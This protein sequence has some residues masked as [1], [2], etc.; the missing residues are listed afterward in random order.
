MVGTSHKG[1][2]MRLQDGKTKLPKIVFNDFA[3][4]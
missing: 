1:K 2:L 4:G 3:L